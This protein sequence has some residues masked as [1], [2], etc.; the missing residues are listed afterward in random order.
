M[1]T[2]DQKEERRDDWGGTSDG[3]GRNAGERF[4]CGDFS[5]SYLGNRR[6]NVV[7]E[8][9]LNWKSYSSSSR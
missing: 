4:A 2:T 9:P 8:A 1:A 6:R 7:Q 3:S 5:D